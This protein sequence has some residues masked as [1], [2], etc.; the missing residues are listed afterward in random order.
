[1]IVWNPGTWISQ[2]WT[3]LVGWGTVA[4]FM[5]RFLSVAAKFTGYGADLKSVKTD[6]ELIKG[7]HIPHGLIELEKINCTLSG[8]REDSTGLRDDIRALLIR[9]P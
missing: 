9:R 6:V 3:Y 4:T 8:M 7:N 5:H 1:M 2:Y